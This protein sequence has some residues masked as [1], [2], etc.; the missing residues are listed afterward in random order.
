MVYS[1]ISVERTAV[2]KMFKTKKRLLCTLMSACLAVGS[3]FAYP[4]TNDIFPRYI[5]GTVADAA[6]TEEQWFDLNPDF[7]PD[8]AAA[9]LEKYLSRADYEALFPYRYGS[10]KCKEQWAKNEPAPETAGLSQAQAAK[11]DDYYSYDNLIAAMKEIADI[12]LK[13]EFRI[14]TAKNETVGYAS[15]TSMLRKSSGET[16]VLYETEGFMEENLMFAP[17]CVQFVDLGAFLA[18]GSENDK[19]REIAALFAN[20]TQETS[21]RMNIDS[22][23]NWGTISVEASNM[24]WGLYWKEEVSHIGDDTALGYVSAGDKTFPPTPGQSY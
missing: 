2:M 20:M 14:N 6:T 10:P 22:N 5:N 24:L 21:G 8:S 12:K 1:S 13:I 15:R 18:E 7:S 19:K 17:V 9:R 16:T 4:I 23:G 11:E 3:F